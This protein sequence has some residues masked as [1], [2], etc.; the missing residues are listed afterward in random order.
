VVAAL[1]ILVFIQLNLWVLGVPLWHLV[2]GWDV[3][4]LLKIIWSPHSTVVWMC[5]LQNLG[6]ANVTGVR[7]GAFERCLGHGGSSL[8][9]GTGSCK[10]GFK[11][12]IVSSLFFS[13]ATW[14]SSDW[15]HLGLKPSPG[16]NASTLILGFPVLGTALYKFPSFRYLV[17]AQMD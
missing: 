15:S 8:M 7:G 14:G 4:F 16:L 11:Q 6:A 13:S 9:N 10:K 3:E 1:V 17:A 12:S 5:L 2:D